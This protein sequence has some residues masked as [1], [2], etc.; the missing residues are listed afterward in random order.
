MARILAVEDSATVLIALTRLLER[1]G[2]EV[3]A[4]SD[5]LAAFAALQSSKPDLVML[6]IGLPM[7][8]GIELCVTIRQMHGHEHTPIIMVTGSHKFIDQRLAQ[9]FG[10]SA[11]ITKPFD[12]AHLIATVNRL[13]DASIA[14]RHQQL[15]TTVL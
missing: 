4:A 15:G 9:E 3:T 5:G 11:Y 6:D 8:G 12:E 1:E 10:A 7:I 13:L 14:E 2:H